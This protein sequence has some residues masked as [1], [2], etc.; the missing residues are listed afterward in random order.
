MISLSHTAFQQEVGQEGFTDAAMENPYWLA[1]HLV[2]TDVLESKQPC[3]HANH[4]YI[5]FHQDL[6]INYCLI[7]T[8]CVILIMSVM[9]TC[10]S[11]C[12]ILCTY[13]NIILYNMQY[14]IQ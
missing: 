8:A 11:N 14:K 2:S 5:V 13:H 1:E 10:L 6:Y 9:N 7:C 4:L 3:S 12:Q